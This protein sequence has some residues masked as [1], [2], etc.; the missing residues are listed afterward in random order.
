MTRA[1]YG[2]DAI[3]TRMALDCLAAMAGAER[4]RRA[5]R[6]SPARRAVLLPDRGAYLARHDRGAP[7]ARPADAS[8]STPAEMARRFPMID[9]TGIDA[10]LFEP[11]FGALMARRAVQTLVAE[12]VRGG[13]AYRQAPVLPPTRRAPLERASRSPSASALQADRFVF[14]LG[15]WLPKLFP[16]LLG[17]RIFADPA[18][19]LLLRA[20]GGRP[21]LPA[22]TPARLGRFQRRRHLLRLPRPRGPRLQV[23]PRRARRRGRPRHAGPRGRRAAAL[24]EIVAFRDRRFPL[25]AGAPL[26]EARVCQ[27]ENSSNGDFLIDRHPR[28][29]TSLLVGGGSGHGFK[30]GPAVGR[31]AAARLFGSGQARAALLPRH[32]GARPRTAKCISR[33]AAVAGRPAAAPSMDRT[34]E[35]RPARGRDHCGM[36][37]EQVRPAARQAAGR[38]DRRRP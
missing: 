5:C 12:F 13:G 1:A 10:G 28:W 33:S 15:P 19:S 14:A 24:A 6:S 25:L 31:Y 32:Q 30:H 11:G 4:D 7:R 16:D 27:Y 3:Y 2:K 23:R 18:G 38:N 35:C 36:P 17:R 9:F 21:P 37:A 8:C 34:G 22:R 29:R 26:T 20:A